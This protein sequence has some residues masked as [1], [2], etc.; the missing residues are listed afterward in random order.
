[1]LA[2]RLYSEDG[3]VRG[4]LPGARPE[5]ESESGVVLTDGWA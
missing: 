5:S 3:V 1:M 4:L 2:R